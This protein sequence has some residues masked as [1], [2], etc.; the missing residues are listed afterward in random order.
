MHVVGYFYLYELK[1]KDLLNTPFI[2][3]CMMF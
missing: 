3:N 1:P 2:L